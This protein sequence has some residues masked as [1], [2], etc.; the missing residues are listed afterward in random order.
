MSAQRLDGN[1]GPGRQAADDP[2]RRAGA[3]AYRSRPFRTSIRG[4]RRRSRRRRAQGDRGH[5]R[6]RLSAERTGPAARAASHHDLRRRRRRPRQP[7]SCR[8]GK[9]GRASR[10]R[11][12]A[13]APCSATR[14][15]TR[16][17]SLRASRACSNTASPESS[18]LPIPVARTACGRCSKGRVPV[19]FVTCSCRLGRCHLRRRRAR[20]RDG[21]RPPDRA[22]SPAHRLLA[23]IRSSRMRPIAPAS[24]AIERAMAAAG[25]NPTVFPLAAAL[26]EVCAAARSSAIEQ[27]ADGA[28][29]GD[30]GSS[31]R[32]IS[33]PSSFSTMPT[34]SAMPVPRISPSS[35]STMSLLPALP[36]SV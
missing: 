10:R 30:G 24:S 28:A 17:P 22:R 26:R 14:R 29:T 3:P 21:D 34:G 7:V 1:R 2:R 9:A 27:I 16:R 32:T 12:A 19:A 36:A 23:P 8:N 20:R 33:V 31:P 5:R 13:I 25:L 18:S 35:G 11:R 4:I 6:A 15:P